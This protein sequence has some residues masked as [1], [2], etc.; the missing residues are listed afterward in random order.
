MM[1]EVKGTDCDETFN[2]NIL[3]LILQEK[4]FARIGGRS[5]VPIDERVMAVTRVI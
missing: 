3:L 4:E 2:K 5:P 1:F